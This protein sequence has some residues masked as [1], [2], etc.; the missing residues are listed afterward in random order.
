MWYFLL[1]RAHSAPARVYAHLFV[2][3]G[4]I[5]L[6]SV[7]LVSCGASTTAQLAYPKPTTTPTPTPMLIPPPTP[8]PTQLPQQVPVILDLRPAS[9]S[10]VGHL[11][12]PISHG[13]YVCQ[14]RVIAPTGNPG[15]LHWS[16]FV[17]FANN[18]VFDPG[19][20]T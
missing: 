11:D 13:D 6:I 20:G 15:P 9:M 14:A 5:P 18:V 16:S 10:F 17:N 12:C 3:F 7:L 19:S 2:L 8:T 4:V 1:K